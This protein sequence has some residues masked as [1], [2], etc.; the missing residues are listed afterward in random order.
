M[1]EFNKLITG[2]TIVDGT[3]LQPYKADAGSRMARSKIG[4]L[5][6]H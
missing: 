3:G 5:K 6:N 4:H 2:G 1:A